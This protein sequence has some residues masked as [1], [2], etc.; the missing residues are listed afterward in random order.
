VPKNRPKEIKADMTIREKLVE[1]PV[2]RPLLSYSEYSDVPSASMVRV[3]TL[4][5]IAVEKIAALFDR[6]RNEARD[7]YDKWFLIENREVVI[8]DLKHKLIEKLEFRGKKLDGVQDEFNKKESRLQK[9]W[10][11]RLS[12]QTRVNEFDEVFR[13]VKREFRKAGLTE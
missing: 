1:A 8:G 10:D 4:N 11:E 3:Y 12:G 5:E 7:L 6:A 2:E 9:K 13:T